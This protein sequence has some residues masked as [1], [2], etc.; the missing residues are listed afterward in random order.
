M[1]NSGT[2]GN[3]SNLCISLYPFTSYTSTYVNRCFQL[4]YPIMYILAVCWPYFIKWH[5]FTSQILTFRFCGTL[6][7]FNAYWKVF[8]WFIF[9]LWCFWCFQILFHSKWNF[10]TLQ[11]LLL[12]IC[13]SVVSLNF[14]RNVFLSC[15]TYN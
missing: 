5:I 2:H 12:F 6:L 10:Y 14:R 15:I 1:R 13:C 9:Y 8:R 4:F 11:K 3:I 7:S